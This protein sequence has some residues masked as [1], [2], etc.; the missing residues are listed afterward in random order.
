MEKLTK[1][2]M[3]VLRKCASLPVPEWNGVTPRQY[4]K[5]LD[6]LRELGL[7]VY[8]GSGGSFEGHNI[9]DTGRAALAALAT[10][11]TGAQDSASQGEA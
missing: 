7:A 2:Q 5:T 4:R 9:T 8:H 1:A 11:S 10:P 3:Q 6:R